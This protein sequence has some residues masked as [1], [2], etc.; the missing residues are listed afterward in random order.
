VYQHGA[1]DSGGFNKP[2][3][4]AQRNTPKGGQKERT[5]R[6]GHEDSAGLVKTFQKPAMLKTTPLACERKAT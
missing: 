6:E 2:F 4:S 3:E 5:A 1:D